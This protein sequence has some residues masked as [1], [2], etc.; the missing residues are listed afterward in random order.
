MRMAALIVL[1]YRAIGDSDGDG[2]FDDLDQCPNSSETYNKFQDDD[3]CPDLVA[4]NKLL[5]DSD[6]DGIQDLLDSVSNTRRNL[7]WN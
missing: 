1:T 4:D 3:G 5:S 7:Q 6:N 2:I